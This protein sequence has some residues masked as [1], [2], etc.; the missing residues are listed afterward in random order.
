MRRTFT[1][2]SLAALMLSVGV[3]VA[4]SPA[5]GG[6]AGE[7]QRPGRSESPGQQAPASPNRA[8]SPSDRGGAQQAQPQ[9]GQERRPGQAETPQRPDQP[10]QAQPQPGQERRPGQA[11]TPQRPDQPR[12]AQPQQGQE[13]RPGQ[14]E[15][16]Q[17]PDQPRQAQP[18]QGQERR[19]GQAE[20]PQRPDQP[21]QAQPQ[22]QPGQRDQRGAEGRQGADTTVTGSISTD[23]ERATRLRTSVEQARVPESRVNVDIRVGVNLPRNVTLVAPPPALIEIAPRYRDYRVTRVGG[24][25]VIV[26]PGTYRVVEVVSLSGRRAAAGAS[27]GGGSTSLTLTTQQRE[28]IRRYVMQGG[29]RTSTRIEVTPGRPLPRQVELMELPDEVFTEVPSL[30]EYRYFMSGDEVVIVDPDTNVVAQV[31]RD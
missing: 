19:P 3:A 20:T 22:T 2:T 8:Q 30:R 14:A 6:G 15:T 24:D 1:G 7:S 11:E 23:P 12:Q 17:R 10:R 28:V 29:A 18:Q 5:P 16:P 25:L 9:Q 31:L 21:R 13:R 27:G 26:D 4:Q